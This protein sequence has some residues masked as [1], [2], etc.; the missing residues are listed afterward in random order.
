MPSDSELLKA[1]LADRDVPCPGC[2]YSLRGCVAESCPECARPFALG[3][4]RE[5][6]MTNHLGLFWS[7]LW[8]AFLYHALIA[9]FIIAE[10]VKSGLAPWAGLPP[11]MAA[12]TAAMR[13]IT[14]CGLGVSVA[15][16]IAARRAN[17]K[18]VRLEPVLTLF[19]WAVIVE[20][21]GYVVCEGAVWL[22]Y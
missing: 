11:P 19:L 1:Y 4:S 6:W 21:C 18:P 20:S 7:A 17:R 13:L 9:A 10:F 15:L 5:P 14:F 8:I 3:V 16:L 12:V 2:G 22:M